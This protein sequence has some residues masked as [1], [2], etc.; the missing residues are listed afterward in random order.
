MCYRFSSTSEA[1]TE[2]LGRALAGLLPDGA[3]VALHGTLGAGKTRLVQAIAAG[4]SVPVEEV[5][6]PTFVLCHT[7]HG[8]RTIHHFDA[9]RV[10]D[11]DE[12]WELG[13]EEYFASPGLTMVEWAE[14]VERCL[15]AT[16]L[17]INITVTGPT[18]RCF[19]FRA[20][21]AGLA[22]VVERLAQQLA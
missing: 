10:H 6:S 2:R 9:F 22:D 5:V 19:E 13:V 18:Q 17:D 21:G 11:E 3:T 14:R 15:P 4:C 1:D 8:L 16:R 20:R 12:F 7:Y